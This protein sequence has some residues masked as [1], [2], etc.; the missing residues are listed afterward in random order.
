MGASDGEWCVLY[1]K[2]GPSLLPHTRG[3][4]EHSIQVEEKGEGEQDQPENEGRA[5][6]VEILAG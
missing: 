5:V 6:Y 4:R 3:F 2:T 1:V